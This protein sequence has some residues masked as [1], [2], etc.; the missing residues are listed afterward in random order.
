MDTSV[1]NR[2]DNTSTDN[3]ST[4]DTSTTSTTADDAR[5]ARQSRLELNLGR[6]ALG[7]LGAVTAAA[8]SAR[9]GVTG[10]LIGTAV[11]SFG[12]GL[13]GTIYQQS[14]DRTRT[15]IAATRARTTSA[16]G[17]STPGYSAE[18]AYPD[19][20]SDVDRMIRPTRVQLAAEWLRR[21]AHSPRRRFLLAGAGAALT[22]TVAL[23]VITA[24]EL[25]TGSEL[26]GGHG[27]TVGAVAGG[28]HGTAYTTVPTKP[29][30]T[31]RHSPAAPGPTDTK[32]SPTPAPTRPSGTP[33]RPSGAPTPTPTPTGAPGGTPS[34]P[35]T[36]PTTPPSTPPT[37]PTTAPS[38]PASPTPTAPTPPA[39]PHPARS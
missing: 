8:L 21:L 33:T 34:T 22:F 9:L 39:S 5:P 18:T 36:T 23:G 19:T 35:P 26:S 28:G 1:D 37:T 31:R 29:T 6:L 16:G 15:A 38:T 7:A 10:T 3:T 30:T 25:G 20:I 14:V 32:P 27:T 4:G 2:L 11:I 17:G 24:I 12:S 13:A